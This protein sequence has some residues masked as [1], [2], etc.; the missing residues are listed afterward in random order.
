MYHTKCQELSD[1]IGA[2]KRRD[3]RRDLAVS[4]RALWGANYFLV[5]RARRKLGGCKYDDG[6]NLQSHLNISELWANTL[7]VGQ[8]SATKSST[9]SFHPSWAPLVPVLIAVGGPIVLESSLLILASLRDQSS[10]PAL[11]ATVEEKA[12][13]AAI[14][15]STKGQGRYHWRHFSIASARPFSM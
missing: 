9:I 1:L 13:D 8:K 2:S 6:Q 14:L 5:L 10:E 3:R 11:P 15:T 7:A 12:M 4:V